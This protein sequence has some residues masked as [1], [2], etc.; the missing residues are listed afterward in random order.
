MKTPM[1]KLTLLRVEASG[2]VVSFRESGNLW[3]SVEL[4]D[5]ASLFSK[6]GMGCGR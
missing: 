2:D 6:V 1:D 5:K 4:T 3:A